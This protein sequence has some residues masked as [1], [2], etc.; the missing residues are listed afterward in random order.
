MALMS[1]AAVRQ[2]KGRPISE[3][4]VHYP[5]GGKR[6][7]R[8]AAR[9]KRM[10]VRKSFPDYM[11]HVPRNGFGGLFIELKR[12]AAP[13]VRAGS[14]TDGQNDQLRLLAEFGYWT[15]VAHGWQQATDIIA[16][17]LGLKRAAA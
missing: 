9:L 6:N 3:L 12:P 14:T 15:A 11:L 7:P 4:L 8:E 10:G 16:D 2:Y 13:G 17:Y 5:A 1:W